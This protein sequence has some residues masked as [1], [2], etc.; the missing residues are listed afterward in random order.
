MERALI[1]KELRERLGILPGREVTFT[2]PEGAVRV[3][4]V[5]GGGS[6]RGRFRGSGMAARLEADRRLE[7]R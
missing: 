6:M 2:E 5:R 4:P 1:P 3:Q 7:P